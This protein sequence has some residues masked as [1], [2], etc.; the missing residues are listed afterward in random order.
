MLPKRPSKSGPIFR[1]TF[2]RPLA[3]RVCRVASARTSV[4]ARR[5]ARALL[6][7]TLETFYE[8][9]VSLRYVPCVCKAISRVC[10]CVCVCVFERIS[11]EHCSCCSVGLVTWVRVGVSCAGDVHFAVL[12]GLESPA[13]S[14]R[15]KAPIWTRGGRVSWLL[16]QRTHVMPRM[17]K[18][19]KRTHRQQL[20]YECLFSASLLSFT[21]PS[22]AP[23]NGGGGAGVGQR[24]EKWR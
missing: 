21:K 18:G 16:L 17:G 8:Q 13:S 24:L 20:Q 11:W 19:V 2:G 15:K 6:D 5:V 1:S 12:Q 10:V 3:L 7:S 14:D 22:N 9:R 23:L 4:V